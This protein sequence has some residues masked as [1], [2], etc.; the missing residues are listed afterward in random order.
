MSNTTTA[1][2]KI[3]DR[4]NNLFI[5]EGFKSF[6]FGSV[7]DVNLFREEPEFPS[8]L[9]MIQPITYDSTQTTLTFAII[10]ADK[11]D[12]TGNSYIEYA[13]DNS[14]DIYQDLLI[15]TQ[16]VL[17]K[18]DERYLSTYDTLKLGYQLQYNVSM[19]PFSED[20]PDLLTGYI[21]K[22]S[23]NVPNMTVC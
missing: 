22:V 2:Y 4:L 20:Y 19:D 14:V 1:L 13:K 21:V 23:F 18:M 8:V 17:N 7:T 12:K 6:T 15:K 10:V 5:A 9:T 16:S 11:V 3:I